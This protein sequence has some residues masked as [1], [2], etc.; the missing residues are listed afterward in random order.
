MNTPPT[1]VGLGESLL[2]LSVPNHGRLDTMTAL[3]VNVGGAEMNTLI[4]VARLGGAATWVTRLADNPLARRIAAHAAGYGV[5]PVIDWDPTSRAPL[6]FVEHGAAPRPSEVLYDR[7]YTA[8]QS[9]RPDHFDWAQHV[10]GADIAYSTG[11]TCALGDSATQAVETFFVAARDAGCRVAFDLNYRGRMWSWSRAIDCMRR[12]LPAV[13]VLFASPRDLRR[14]HDTD[15][16]PIDLARKTIADAG[17][18]LVVLRESQPVPGRTVS[19]TV[20]AVSHDGEAR[21]A[22][23][24]GLSL[25]PF[26]AGDAATG[27][28][29]TAWWQAGNLTEAAELA[30]WACAH[31][32]T[33][34]GDAWLVRPDDVEHRSSVPGLRNINR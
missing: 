25:D 7:G 14:L 18:D 22:E 29:L 12:I 21:S 16:D 27:A 13:D 11:I 15:A 8:M 6:Y 23:H 1:V 28:F 24:N 26:G 33:I 30:A 32:H 17:P 3:D 20:T 4:A 2:R 10:D 31:Q 9:L 19:V 34:S 5:R